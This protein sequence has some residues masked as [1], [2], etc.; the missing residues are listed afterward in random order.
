MKNELIEVNSFNFLLDIIKEFKS[1]SLTIT[2][3]GIIENL[4]RN[5]FGEYCQVFNY[6]TKLNEFIN[7]SNLYN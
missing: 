4:K 7:Y 2:Q 5:L 3:L 1:A 6:H